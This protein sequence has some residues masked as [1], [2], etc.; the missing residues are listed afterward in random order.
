VILRLRAGAQPLAELVIGEKGPSHGTGFVR[1]PGDDKT[2]RVYKNMADVIDPVGNEWRDKKIFNEVAD[3]VSE[4]TL[5]TRP[6]VEDVDDGGTEGP[7]RGS[8]VADGGTESPAE[9]EVVVIRRKEASAEWELVLD[10]GSAEALDKS[11]TD[12]LARSLASLKAVEFAADVTVDDAGL[13]PPE[14]E[15]IFKLADGT[16]HHLLVGSGDGSKVFVK[17]AD[18]KVAQKVYAYNVN[19]IFKN[20]DALLPLPGG[21]PPMRPPSPIMP[22]PEPIEIAPAPEEGK[23]AE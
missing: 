7:A 14:K 4:I 8:T 18:W 19:N 22:R 11:K 12:A 17:R 23:T 15:A 6:V 16:V 3:D 10:G 21:A 2:Y 13:N 5:I 20:R 9:P 1:K